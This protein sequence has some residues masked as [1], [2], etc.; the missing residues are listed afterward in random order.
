MRTCL[1]KLSISVCVTVGLISGCKSGDTA[2]PYIAKSPDPANRGRATIVAYRCGDCHTIPGV[3]GAKGV[4]GPPLN[5]ISRRT[6]IGGNFPNTS[7]NLMHWVMSPQAMKPK[8][9]MPVLG[10]SEPQARDIAAYLDTL[11]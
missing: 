5:S 9:A 10:L 2:H 11:K 6:Y 8:T 3:R 7:D 1:R 4:F